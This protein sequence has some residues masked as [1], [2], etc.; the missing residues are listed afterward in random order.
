MNG[1]PSITAARE[2]SSLEQTDPDGR[3]R[4]LRLARVCCRW[5]R[6]IRSQAAAMFA[7]GQHGFRRLCYFQV[8]AS[9]RQSPVPE[10]VSS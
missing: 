3:W 9:L 7:I 4:G 8:D 10:G 5:P 2:R 6:M 1:R